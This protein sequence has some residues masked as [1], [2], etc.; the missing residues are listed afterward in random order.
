MISQADRVD[1]AALPWLVAIGA[2]WMAL[3]WALS[4]YDRW[5]ASRGAKFIP[6]GPPGLRAGED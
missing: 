3:G 1:A 6:N 4:V 2:A 5:T